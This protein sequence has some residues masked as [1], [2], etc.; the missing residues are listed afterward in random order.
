LEEEPVGSKVEEVE[1]EGEELLALSGVAREEG[2]CED[3]EGVEEE[4]EER[5]EEET[6][7]EVPREMVEAME[8]AVETAVMI[9]ELVIG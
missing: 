7:G 3:G 4:V 1:L 5:G 9:G 8:I 6:V 2:E